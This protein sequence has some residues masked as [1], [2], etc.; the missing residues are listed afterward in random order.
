[1]RLLINSKQQKTRIDACQQCP[2]YTLKKVSYARVSFYRCARCGC[3]IASKTKVLIS[4]C[5]LGRW[6]L[7]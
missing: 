4:Q 5:P 7:E 3:P 2:E 6:P 1:M